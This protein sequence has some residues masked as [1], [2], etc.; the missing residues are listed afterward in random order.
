MFNFWVLFALVFSTLLGVAVCMRISE[1]SDYLLTL[2]STLIA[3]GEDEM[4]L[5]H[6]RGLALTHWRLREF[7]KIDRLHMYLYFWVPCST[8]IEDQ[9]FL[10]PVHDL[11]AKRVDGI[12]SDFVE[13]QLNAGTFGGKK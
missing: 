9:E 10:K 11:D 7:N 8:F 3:N 1:V 13:R 4:E 6:V 2:L 12:V 5:D